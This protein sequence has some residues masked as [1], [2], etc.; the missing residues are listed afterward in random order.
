[1]VKQKYVLF[2][3]II[4]IFKCILDPNNMKEYGFRMKFEGQNY[5][6]QC[7]KLEKLPL[8]FFFK[9]DENE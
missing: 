7:L 2:I 5:R 3:N 6:E 4:I 9:R 1:M 8:V